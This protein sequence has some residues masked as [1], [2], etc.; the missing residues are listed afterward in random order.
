MFMDRSYEQA[1]YMMWMRLEMS[2]EVL[3]LCC[4]KDWLHRP[5]PGHAPLHTSSQNIRKLESKKRVFD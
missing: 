3:R 4:T 1:T 2:G 5:L